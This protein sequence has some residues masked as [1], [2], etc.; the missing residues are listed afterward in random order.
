ML[1][2]GGDTHCSTL[3]AR[4]SDKSHPTTK[5]LAGS[6]FYVAG[7]QGVLDNTNAD[8]TPVQRLETHPQL[9]RILR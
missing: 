4:T 6:V 1:W 5:G 9:L 8:C 7:Q 3:L 2:L